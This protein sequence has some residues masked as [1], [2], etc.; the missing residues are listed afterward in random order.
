MELSMKLQRY[1]VLTAVK[2]AVKTTQVCQLH[3]HFQNCHIWPDY[4]SAGGWQLYIL[5]HFG[6][7]GASV[8]CKYFK[9]MCVLFAILVNCTVFK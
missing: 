1:A 8:Q 4:P 9:C 7:Y 3:E 5:V 2:S 6:P